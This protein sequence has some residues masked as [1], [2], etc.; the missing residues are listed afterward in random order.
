MQFCLGKLRGNNRTEVC[1]GAHMCHE[2]CATVSAS[3]YKEVVIM[4]EMRDLLHFTL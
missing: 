2:N 4:L 1:H 3:I